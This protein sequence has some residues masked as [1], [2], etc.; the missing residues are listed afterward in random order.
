MKKAVETLLVA[1]IVLFLSALSVTGIDYT[2][3]TWVDGNG[4]IQSQY[5]LWGGPFTTVSQWTLSSAGALQYTGDYLNG[6]KI[7][8]TVTPPKDPANLREYW[9][10]K[11]S[12][13]VSSFSRTGFPTRSTEPSFASTFNSFGSRFGGSKFKPISGFGG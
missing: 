9:E 7:R 3:S 11:P 5:T 4:V 13:F 1:A 2:S 8:W 12:I 6:G 10:D